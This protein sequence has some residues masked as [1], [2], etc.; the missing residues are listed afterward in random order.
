MAQSTTQMAQ[1]K[2][3]LQMP[4][5]IRDLLVT[6][7]SPSDDTTYGLHE[8]MGNFQPEEALLCAAFIM[9]D[10]AALESDQSDDLKF[11]HMECDRIIDRYCAR[12]DL[13]QENPELWTKTEGDTLHLIADDIEDF[14]EVVFLC[15]MTFE[16]TNPQRTDI[17]NIITA[18]LQSH[19]MIVDEVML[20]REDMRTESMAENA[21]TKET[22]IVL[23][24]VN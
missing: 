6:G 11:L 14:L 5:L 17:L 12:D 23:F 8:M 7:L 20:L 1:L 4:M 9:K 2:N 24:P 19:A 21:V 10:I 3:R 15:Y 22:N 13:A 18:Q 16:I